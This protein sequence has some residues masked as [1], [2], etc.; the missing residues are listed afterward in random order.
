MARRS[1]VPSQPQSESLSNIHPSS[2]TRTR[3]HLT[4]LLSQTQFIWS[5]IGLA[6]LLLA[7]LISAILWLTSESPIRLLERAEAASQDHSWHT[8]LRYWRAVN[9]TKAAGSTTYL[10]EAKVC[11]AL[12]YARQAER[13]LRR[14]IVADQANAEAWRLLLEI[15]RVEERI[16]EAQAL[17]WE[18][19]NQL[20]DRSR[21]DLLRELT[22]G[23]LAEL[24]D[25]L[26]R[27]TL[28]RWVD[29]DQADIDARVALIERMAAQPRA[30]DPDRPVLL[31]QLE[32]ILAE[33]P[34]HIGARAALVSGL[35]DSGEFKHGRT[36]LEDWPKSLHDA[37]YWRLLGRW[38]LE[39]DHRPDR[40]AIA[41]QNT[42]N[43]LP[44]D[45]QTWYR[46]ARARRIVGQYT[47][48]NQA[49]ETVQRIR[50]ALDPLVLRPRLN[51]AFD[52]LDDL[53]SINVLAGICEQVGLHRLATAWRAEAKTPPL[54]PRP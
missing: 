37:R 31:A 10:G 20:H 46:L 35:A 4:Y 1:P 39:Y 12:G 7:S 48:S 26:A 42:L 11:L 21:P 40:A 24:P 15:L 8:A 52:H 16:V 29:A 28:Q 3:L 17:G 36:V 53:T 54:P 25:E 51:N 9:N 18:A 13:N 5:L 44:Q 38:E 19:Y 41:F 50:E 23:A 2:R 45:W 32:H 22:L 6:V 49:A 47:A 33:H 30:S 14:A 43:D 27:T 34:E